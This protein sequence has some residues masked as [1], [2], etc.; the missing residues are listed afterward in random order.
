MNSRTVPKLV[1][2]WFG[3]NADNPTRTEVKRVL[4]GVHSMLNNVDYVYPGDQCSAN[5][6]AYVF[7]QSPWNKKGGKYLFYLCDYYMKVGDG[8]KIETLIHEGAHH[9]VMV[10][11]DSKWK[12]KTMYGRT[13]CTSVA[14]KCAAGDKA[15]CLLALRNADTFCYFVNDAA[16]ASQGK[17]NP[18]DPAVAPQA[19]SSGGGV[20]GSFR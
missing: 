8:E 3:N 15:A 19:P 14:Q 13:L 1:E 6:Y 17:T 11:Q 12:G 4:A 18:L 9:Q 5:S 20:G 2:T 7:P 10:A 16:L